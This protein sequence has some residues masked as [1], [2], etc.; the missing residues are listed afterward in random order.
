MSLRLIGLCV[1][2]AVAGG[3]FAFLL[4]TLV[5]G[6]DSDDST[7]TVNDD[8]RTPGVAA[9]IPQQVEKLQ[10]DPAN[11]YG[12]MSFDVQAVCTVEQFAADMADEPPPGGF[13]EIK[14]ITY[15]DDGTADVT[16][17]L[18]EET[19]DVEVTW[20]L[21]FLPNNLPKIVDI[22]GMDECIPA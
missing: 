19:G 3:A 6:G 21:E 8:P 15:N 9:F 13:R 18:I 2:A 12:V 16:I 14:E 7:D 22:P 11:I 17:V 20:R 1:G 5:G 10:L 4:Y